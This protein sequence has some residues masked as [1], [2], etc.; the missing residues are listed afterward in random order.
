[1][2]EHTEELFQRM[3]GQKEIPERLRENYATVK[4]FNDRIDAGPINLHTL[5]LIACLTGD[6]SEDLWKA[7]DGNGDQVKHAHE[8]AG[9]KDS[10]GP[11]KDIKDGT[12]VIVN[13]HGKKKGLF[14]GV[15]DQDKLRIEV[16]GG[17]IREIHAEK[18]QLKPED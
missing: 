18:V 13:W 8:A 4:C 12:P 5:A 7:S 17:A 1:M 6:V 3:I 10:T 2:D 9:R 16:S 14:R 11:W 15:V